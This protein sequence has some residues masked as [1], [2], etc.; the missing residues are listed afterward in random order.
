MG[1]CGSSGDVTNE[2]ESSRALEAKIAKERLEEQ[3]IKK[4][5][6][7]GAGESGKSTLFKQTVSLYGKGFTE[8][9]RKEYT[10]IIFNNTLASIKTLAEQSGKYGPVAA[11]VE[12]SKR[13]V[14]EWKGEDSGIDKVL[15]AHI[16]VL[17]KDAGIQ[18]TYQQR[19]SYQLSDCAEY[20]LDKID[21]LCS[22][23]YIPTEKDIL[24][25]R[26]PTTG[27]VQHEF[28]MDG[29]QFKMY[30]VGGQRNE[31]KKWIHCFEHVTAV[32]FVAAINEYDMRLYEDGNTNRM[33]EA[34]DLFEEICN[35]QWFRETSMILFLNKR[36]LF[37]AKIKTVPLTVCFK[38][39]SGPNTY[40]AGSA[41]IQDQFL[42]KNQNPKRIYTHLT[43]ATDTDNV[44]AVFDAVYDIVIR[45]AIRDAGLM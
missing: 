9:E 45:N 36:D 27:I 31:R 18:A 15:G 16:K 34:L 32:L 3:Q 11:S 26:A 29:T 30:D 8:S 40:E 25:C 24:R 4:L 13:A 12:D 14:E 41:F 39:Y 19:S 38:N 28:S 35:S 37:A 10:R 2:K 6:L 20:F 1:T 21:Q 22:P 33:V 17:W 43:C 7:L 23:G 44:R 42:S 5:L